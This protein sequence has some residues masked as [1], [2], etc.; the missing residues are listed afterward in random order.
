M[1][2]LFKI[3]TFALLS[4]FIASVPAGAATI[5]KTHFEGGS[6]LTE[7]A[8]KGKAGTLADLIIVLQDSVA[9]KQN[10]SGLVAITCNASVGGAATE[11][12]TCTG[13]LT[14]D[15]I[16]AVSQ[17]TKG[18]NSLPLLGWGTVV[19]NGLTATWSAN[20]GAGAV[21]VVGVKR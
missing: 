1:K 4:M 3:F 16:L 9:L 20:P 5:K 15:T 17:K 11:A 18:A 13:L 6:N 21:L 8:K 12:L 19:A 10:A 2:S 14:T 7:G